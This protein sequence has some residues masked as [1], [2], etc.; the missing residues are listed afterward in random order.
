MKI[1]GFKIL[2]QKLF[3]DV[4]NGRVREGFFVTVNKEKTFFQYQNEAEIHAAELLKNT[5]IKQVII[6]KVQLNRNPLN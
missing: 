1:K 6:S 4:Q 3:C 2:D 5:K